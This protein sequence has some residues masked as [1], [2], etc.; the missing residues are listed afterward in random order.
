MN[1]KPTQQIWQQI[2]KNICNLFDSRISQASDYGAYGLTQNQLNDLIFNEVMPPDEQAM[3]EKLGKRY[4]SEENEIRVK[5]SDMSD[6][7]IVHQ[8]WTYEVHLNTS[9]LMPP[10]WSGWAGSDYCKVRNP[11][12]VDI[13]RARQAAID[14]ITTERDTMINNI[15]ELY[16][17]A[18]SINTLIKVWPPIENL[19]PSDVIQKIHQ[20]VERRAPEKILADDPS[21]G[22][23]T[24]NLSV[25]FL[26]AR[27]SA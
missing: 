17:K 9:R 12:V 26:K 1:V 10:R 24:S 2:E 27:I 18:K 8:S 15:K 25:D 21:L 14:A 19:L 4:F 3:V 7:G 13:F 6:D 5:I 11:A 20:K 23:L 22:T 16:K